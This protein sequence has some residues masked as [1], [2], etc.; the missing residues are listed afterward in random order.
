MDLDHFIEGSARRSTQDKRL[1]LRSPATGKVIGSAPLGSREDVALAVAAGERAAKSDSWSSRDPLDRALILRRVADALSDRLQEYAA[2]ESEV[3]GRPIREMRAQMARLP[4]WFHYFAGIARGLEGSVVPF[5]GPYLNYTQYAPLGVVGLLTPWN[6]PLLILVKKLAAALAAGN[7]VVVK[8][9]ELAPL[10]ALD[11]ARVATEAG[12]PPGVLNVVSGDGGTGA[13]L[14]ESPS[15]A[16]LDLTGGTQTGQRVATAAAERIVPVTL[17]LGGKAPVVVFEDTPLEEAV[18]AC[19][20]AGFIASG[21]TCISGTRFLIQDKIYDAFVDR[22]VSKVKSIRL[23]DPADP[24]TE[25]GPVISERQMHRALD[26]IRIGQEEGAT[27]A[28]G[29]R[30]AQLPPPLDV[31]YYVE[32]TVFVDVSA[33]MRVFRE[34]IFGPVVCVSRFRDEAEAIRLANDSPFGLGASVWTRDIGRGHRVA[35]SITAGIVWINDHHK[36]DPASVW[37]GFGQSGYGKENGWDA[38]R[39]YM[40]KQSVVV[41]LSEGFSDWYGAGEDKRYG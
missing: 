1:V 29:G 31:G 21:Q 33:G 6:H 4:E 23:G 3:T 36:N 34:E 22:F 24:A 32:P 39:E 38:L 25:M 2:L 41:R 12:L 7:C 26:Y 16:H 19:T 11:F 18:A 14:C 35:K 13:S 17:E 15:I 9:S 27:L 40:R 37:G 10:S 8:P 20:F 5:K 28:C 30:R